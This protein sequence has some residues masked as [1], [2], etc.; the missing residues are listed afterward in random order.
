VFEISSRV[1]L[2]DE[3]RVLLSS[4]VDVT[5]QRRAREEVRTL[6]AT[7]EARVRQRT[8]EL[9]QAKERL[10]QAMG[11]LVQS[12]KL[13]SLGAVV[14]GVA[15][16]LNTPLGNALTVASALHAEVRQCQRDAAEGGLTRTR[17]DEFMRTSQTAAEL[18][19]RNIDRAARQI[20]T[21]KQ[22]AVDQ[23]SERRREF[24]LC[25]IV[26]EALLTFAP[27]LARS[28]HRLTVDIPEGIRMDSYP[29][30]LEQVL[31]NLVTN[32]LI[33]AFDDTTGG[34]MRLCATRERAD[35]IV[36]RFE[37]NGRGMSAEVAAHVFDPFYTTRLGQ[38]GSGLGLYIAYNFV[39]GM[40]GGQVSLR[41]A[42]GEGAGFV[43]RL[44]CVAP[45]RDAGA[46]LPANLLDAGAD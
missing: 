38:G 10:E 17:F 24:D 22:V 6:N 46:V 33:H 18:L 35:E 27:R 44:P 3:Q 5:E 37:D 32:A 36:L 23:T 7:L 16:E 43:V 13:A 42:P 14:A 30:P 8:E 2:L 34:Q 21:F 1:V 45:E 28:P 11:Q 4:L 41:T 26:D 15:H 9:L 20:N 25:D 40:L 31:A 19:E 39:T 12:E 29:G